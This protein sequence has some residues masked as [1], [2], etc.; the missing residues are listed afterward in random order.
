MQPWYQRLL[1]RTSYVGLGFLAFGAVLD[2]VSNAISFIS[3][4]LVV[5]GTVLLSGVWG[6]LELAVKRGSLVWVNKDGVQRP[7]LRLGL[8]TRLPLAG[9]LLLLWTPYA[10]GVLKG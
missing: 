1:V 9:A 8:Q 2:S 10:I 4:P 3:V 6:V 5:V 7:V